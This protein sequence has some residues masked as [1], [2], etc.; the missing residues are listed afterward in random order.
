MTIIEILEKLSNAQEKTVQGKDG[1]EYIKREISVHEASVSDGVIS[2][3]ESKYAIKSYK[4]DDIY[5]IS[6]LKFNKNYNNIVNK[7]YDAVQPVQKSSTGGFG[8]SQFDHRSAFIMNAMNNTIVY[9][10]ANQEDVTRLEVVF[11]KIY[12]KMLKEYNNG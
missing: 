12:N 9:L 4:Y 8:K 2:E 3:L 10:N 5:K 11:D 6:M 7:N 1:K